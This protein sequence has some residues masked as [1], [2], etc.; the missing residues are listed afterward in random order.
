MYPSTISTFSKVSPSDR[1]NNPSHSA[2]ENQQSSTIGQ[3]QAVVGL[4]G[5]APG[6]VIGDLRSSSSNGGGHVQTANK[7]GTGQTSYTKGDLLIATS[8]SVLSRLAV[9]ST[10]GEFLQVDTTQ[11]T[12]MRWGASGT[13]LVISTTS[14][15]VARGAAS[16]LTT[17]FATSIAGSVMGNISGIRFTGQIPK[18][19]AQGVDNFV[20]NV[21]YGVNTIA[22][23]TMT[24]GAS[25]IGAKGE[26]QGMIVNNNAATSQIGYVKMLAAGD[27]FGPQ[28]DRIQ[29]GYAYNYGSASVNSSIDQNLIIQGQFSGVSNKNSILTG[30][31]VVEKIS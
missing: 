28:G 22:S 11:A 10:T 17:L 25:I 27:L 15:S 5:D 1:L 30:L 3:I 8:S 21:N 24:A 9:S 19:E 23:F 4:S 26:I 16:A 29:F 13:K 12:G 31:F 14:V 7:G 20:L 2:L 18:F 6:T